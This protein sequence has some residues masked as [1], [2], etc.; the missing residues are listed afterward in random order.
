MGIRFREFT[1]SVFVC[2]AKTGRTRRR[3]LVHATT[4]RHVRL[5]RADVLF[6]AVL[7]RENSSRRRPPIG[8]EASDANGIMMRAEMSAENSPSHRRRR[9]ERPVFP[10]VPGKSS[11]PGS[12][13]TRGRIHFFQAG[14]ARQTAPKSEAFARLVESGFAAKRGHSTRRALPSRTY[15]RSSP[16][17]PCT[18]SMVADSGDEMGSRAGLTFQQISTFDLRPAWRVGRNSLPC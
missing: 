9:L 14:H 3:Y 7:L 16:D 11:S 18:S 15:H 1:I 12:A 10:P 17:K 6:D 2:K 5:V 4:R 13:A 8:M